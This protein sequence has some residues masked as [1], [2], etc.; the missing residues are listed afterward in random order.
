VLILGMNRL[1]A[2]CVVIERFNI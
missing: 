2:S 1:S